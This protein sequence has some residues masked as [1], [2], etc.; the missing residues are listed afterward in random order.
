MDWKNEK[1]LDLIECYKNKS[2]LWSPKQLKHYNK[3]EK[4][5]AWAELATEMKTTSDECREKIT[6]INA[7]FRREKMKMKNSQRTGTGNYKTI[8][9]NIKIIRA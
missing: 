5:D 4:S 6:S 3:F 1:V 7:S 9:I 8:F 2:I